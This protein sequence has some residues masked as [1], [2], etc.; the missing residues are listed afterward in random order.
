[1]GD[2][3]VRQDAVAQVE[4]VRPA[5]EGVKDALDGAFQGVAAGNQRQRIEIAL[6]GRCFGRLAVAAHKGSTVSSRPTASTP[7]SLA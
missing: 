6:D 7:V 3:R 4:D 5:G 2:R 1:M